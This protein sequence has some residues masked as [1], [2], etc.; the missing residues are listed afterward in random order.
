V[1]H[2]A[3]LHLGSDRWIDVQ[4]RYLERHVHEPFRVYA[5]VNGPAEQHAARFYFALPTSWSGSARA[6]KPGSRQGFGAV[7]TPDRP[8]GSQPEAGSEG[9]KMN[10]LAQ[11]IAEEAAPDDLLVFL[12]GDAFPIADLSG[13]LH[14]LLS[15]HPLV[16]VR[17]DEDAND[18]RAHTSFCAT[19]VGFWK[20]IEGDW[21]SGG[22]KWREPDGEYRADIG[23]NLLK[24]LIEREIDWTP[25]LRTNEKNVHHVLFGIYGNLIYHHGAGFRGPFTRRDLLRFREL[26]RAGELQPQSFPEFR[27][28]VVEKNEP[29]SEQVFERIRDSDSFPWDLF[30]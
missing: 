21:R 1:I 25:L 15:K 29:L 24:T 27:R 22:Y 16:A 14:D 11:R 4:L 8:V 26:V 28:Q 6:I 13:P 23:A 20:E 17:V 18:P 19:T 30:R 2:I 5:C 7:S 10:W 3:T 12:D 9:Q